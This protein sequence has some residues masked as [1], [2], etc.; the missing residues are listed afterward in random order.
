MI[1]RLHK[2]KLLIGYLL[3]VLALVQTLSIE[4]K[5]QRS[6]SKTKNKYA[7]YPASD[8]G[9]KPCPDC[10]IPENLAPN[11][12][13]PVPLGFSCCGHSRQGGVLADSATYRVEPIYPEEA[14]K[15]GIE[16]H[17]VL[18]V[19]VDEEG[20]VSKA[21]PLSGHK[22]L[23]NAAIEA[24]KGWKFSPTQLNGKPVKVLG[25]ITFNFKEKEAKK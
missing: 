2:S 17:V 22:L 24:A 1:E 19:I 8:Q 20:K 5:T 3:L 12:D 18:E 23:R 25:T 6:K 16:G 21:R 9:G 4:G 13:K 15:K 14:K 10:P 11:S 7:K